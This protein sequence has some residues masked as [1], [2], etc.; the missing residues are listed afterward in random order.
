MTRSKR[1]CAVGSG[2]ALLLALSVGA[3]GCTDSPESVGAVAGAAGDDG[4]HAAGAPHAGSTPQAAAGADAGSGTTGGDASGSGGDGG[5]AG[6]NTGDGGNAGDAAGAGGQA[7]SESFAATDCNGDDFELDPEWVNYCVVLSACGASN[8]AW[9]LMS[10]K[11]GYDV[12]VSGW[13][14]DQPYSFKEPQH[15]RFELASCEKQISTCD[16]LLA[17][18]GYRLLQNDCDVDATAHCDGERAVNC[19]S[20]PG[21]TAGVQDCERLS[22]EKGAC[23]VVGT[24]ADARALCV[25]KATCDAPGTTTCDGTK[26]VTC[27][28]TGVGGGRDCAQFG[29]QCRTS[30]SEAFCAPALPTQT[31]DN[32]GRLFCAENAPAYCNPDGIA[33]KAP[34]CGATGDLVCSGGGADHVGDNWWDCVP[35]GCSFTAWS[36]QGGTCEGDELV[37]DTGFWSVRI[38]CTDY[39]L[40]CENG[41][42]QL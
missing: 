36:S 22:G 7:T 39:G 29:L 42:C 9:C 8:L 20:N 30:G 21:V 31:C 6:A 25:V 17:C 18:S 13:R 28:A 15:D 40:K 26:L 23:Q 24:G 32:K 4:S 34:D 38:R 27:D 11:T 5:T 1:R 33:F 16:D 41:G 3:P 19:D 37:E 2:L 35:R 10:P 12:S 14:P